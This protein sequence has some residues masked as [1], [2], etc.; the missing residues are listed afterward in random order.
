VTALGKTLRDP[1]VKPRNSLRF[2]STYGVKAITLSD[3]AIDRDRIRAAQRAGLELLLQE[4][5]PG[6]ASAHHYV[7][8]FVDRHAIV[9]AKFARRRIRTYP[10]PFGDSSAMM[11]IP[12]DDA[13]QPI[14]ML[15]RLLPALRYRGIFSAEFK[16]DARDG[17]FKLIEI[18]PRAW[19]GVSL[20]VAC[21]VN[22]IEM[23]Y[24]D[25]L[26]LDV[27]G[28][29]RYPIGRQWVYGARDAVAGW[30][31]LHRGEL[32]ARDWIRSW[33]GAVQPVA[34]WNDP[35]PGVVELIHGLRRM[36]TP[37]RHAHAEGQGRASLPTSRP[38]GEAR[39]R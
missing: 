29:S 8:G 33:M 10:E 32:R 19:G 2:R 1:F 18:N 25:A 28:V 7:D 35:L 13:R 23:A 4:L 34:R 12:L 15:E 36:A 22:V 16:R 27:P 9:K 26:G 38:R 5:I 39:P 20:P 14:A 21:G 30:R 24:R 6:P 3:A 37:R 17:E 11:T 31:L